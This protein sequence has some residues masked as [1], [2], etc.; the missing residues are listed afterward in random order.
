MLVVQSSPRLF[1]ISMMISA[2]LFLVPLI[3]GQALAGNS[4]RHNY[5]DYGEHPLPSADTSKSPIITTTT[6]SVPFAGPT[7]AIRNAGQTQKLAVYE[8]TG[9]YRGEVSFVPVARLGEDSTFSLSKEG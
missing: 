1:P 4:G 3:A 5:H 2:I 6:S 7:F 9:P 8:D